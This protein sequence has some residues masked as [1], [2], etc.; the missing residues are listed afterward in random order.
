MSFGLRRMRRLV[1]VRDLS[2]SKRLH[3]GNLSV[4]TTTEALTEVFQ[5]DGRKVSRVTLV[6]S[7]DPGRSRG[8]AFVEMETDGDALDAVRLLH[9]A[10]CDGRELRVSMAH[11]PRSRFGGKLGGRPR[12]SSAGSGRPVAG[13]ETPTAGTP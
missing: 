10:Q 13:P 6:M 7:R 3:V 9:G 5:R 2:M 11:G 8:F 1:S 12:A 4:D